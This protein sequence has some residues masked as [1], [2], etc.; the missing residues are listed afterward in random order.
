MS[1]QAT[2]EDARRL[3][4]DT[5]TPDRDCTADELLARW[6]VAIDLIHTNCHEDDVPHGDVHDLRHS[7]C[8]A[9]HTKDP[10]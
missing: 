3:A 9:L 7:L 2:I 10:S 4:P 5:R 8:R 6:V 1:W